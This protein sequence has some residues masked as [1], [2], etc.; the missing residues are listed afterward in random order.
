MRFEKFEKFRGFVYGEKLLDSKVCAVQQVVA[1]KPSFIS[2]FKTSRTW[3]SKLT[4]SLISSHSFWNLHVFCTTTY[5][6]DWVLQK[7]YCTV[8]KY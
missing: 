1:I 6:D 8:L 7:A 3:V 2:N 4:T 5:F